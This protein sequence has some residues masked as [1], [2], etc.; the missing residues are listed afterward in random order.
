MYVD[1]TFLH[2]R[3][4]VVIYVESFTFVYKQ[5]SRDLE[6]FAIARLQFFCSRAL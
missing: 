5:G 4:A 6:D 1:Y 2:S 3:A